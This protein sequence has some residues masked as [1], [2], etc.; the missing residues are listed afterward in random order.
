MN[1]KVV[2]STLINHPMPGK[3]QKLKNR[4]KGC[5][6]FF[7]RADGGT[8]IYCRN[9]KRPKSSFETMTT[10][11]ALKKILIVERG[12]ACESCGLTHWLGQQ[13][14]LQLDHIDGNCD[15]NSRENLRL[16]CPT[17][18][19]LT[20]TWGGRNGGRFPSSSRALRMKKYR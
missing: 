16:V 5:N 2:S 15:L 14:P 3:P 13:I 10:P 1:R 17:C 9:C 8:N 18:H 12:Y 11:S 6:E 7:R 19:S 4:C 20:E